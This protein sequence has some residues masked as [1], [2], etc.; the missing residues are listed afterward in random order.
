MSNRETED[1]PSHRLSLNTNR[2]QYYRRR[3]FSLKIKRETQMKKT[4]VHI[5]LKGTKK[6]INRRKIGSLQGRDEK[7]CPFISR[8]DI[9]KLNFST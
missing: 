8:V 6:K 5:Q 1:K 4:R 9:I 3:L 2:T 7:Q